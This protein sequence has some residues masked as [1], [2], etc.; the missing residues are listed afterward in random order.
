MVGPQQR[1]HKKKDQHY[2]AFF[3]SAP[4]AAAS[5]SSLSLRSLRLS[6]A[7]RARFL[8]FTSP[9]AAME[10]MNNLVGLNCVVT[11]S[12]EKEKEQGGGRSDEDN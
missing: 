11:P 12:D 10:S 7:P 8:F 6:H 3:G 4:A 9:I 5:F 1:S 2:C